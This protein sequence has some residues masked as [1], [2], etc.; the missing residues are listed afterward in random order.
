MSHRSEGWLAVSLLGALMALGA[1]DRSTPASGSCPPVPAASVAPI[2]RALLAFL[3]KAKAAHHQ[4]DI[5][6][7]DGDQNGAI[8]ALQGLVA[9]P[10]PGGERPAIEIREVMADSRARMAGLLSA[11]SEHDAAEAQ[12]RRGLAELPERNLYRGRLM[13]MLGVVE[14]ARYRAF[15]A[16]GEHDKASRAKARAVRA[17][18]GAIS[19]QDE[20][21]RRLL[22][23]LPSAPES[24]PGH[25]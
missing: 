6:Q 21:I 14:E 16:A 19:I 25:P 12:L 2:D 22:P 15:K 9:G 24:R 18:D 10:R 4:A 17:F 20:V 5:A 23:P 7:D 1:C 11:T 8:A 13:E 3:S